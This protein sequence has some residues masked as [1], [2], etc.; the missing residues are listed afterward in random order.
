[1]AIDGDLHFSVL[2]GWDDGDAS[3]PFHVFADVVGVIAAI[4]QENA[5]LWTAL[6]DRTIALVVGDLSA[7]DLG[8]YGQAASVNAEMNLGREATFRA[9]KTLS[10]SPP[11]APAAQ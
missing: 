8:G 9:P 7:G 6:H 10:L 4:S 5:R 1:M 11:F 2:A 3:A